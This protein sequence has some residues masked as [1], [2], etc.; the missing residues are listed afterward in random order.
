MKPYTY[1][2]THVQIFPY[3]PNS[4][5]GPKYTYIL[6][7]EDVGIFYQEAIQSAL[8]VTV[9]GSTHCFAKVGIIFSFANVFGGKW[10]SFP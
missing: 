6:K 2:Y 3:V 10:F 7:W 8:S 5:A 4:I 1:L 9:Y